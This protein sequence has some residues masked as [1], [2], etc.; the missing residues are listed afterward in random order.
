M[1]AI[2]CSCD[3]ECCL[4]H[5]VAQLVHAFR[6]RGHLLA[7]LD[8]LQRP[9]DGPWQSEAVAG[10]NGSPAAV[11]A[12]SWCAIA[13][14][15][16]HADTLH[17]R[18]TMLC[19]KGDF[20]IS[21]SMTCSPLPL[22][23]PSV[24][25]HRGDASLARILSAADGADS[26]K[27]RAAALAAALDLEGHSAADRSGQASPPLQR[28]APAGLLCTR[29]VMLHGGAKVLVRVESGGCRV[30]DLDGLLSGVSGRRHW[31]LGSLVSHLRNSYCS[32]LA[33]E[34]AHLTNA[35]C[36]PIGKFSVWY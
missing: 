20:S 17:H 27:Q 2:L 16:S 22:H 30:Y 33:V 11:G 29:L 5:Q 18:E 10:G 24:F 36:G 32:T 14:M 34:S 1:S 3:H 35:R 8:P 25:G 12:Q 31:T 23:K 15:C 28:T 9:A 21:N 26:E 19:L 13:I 4:W 6:A 7:R